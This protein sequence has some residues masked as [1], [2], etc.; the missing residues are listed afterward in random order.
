VADGPHGS[1]VIRVGDMCVDLEEWLME[2]VA[3]EWAYMTACN[4]GSVRLPGAENA[5]RSIELRERLVA[6]GWQ[7][8]YGVSVGRDGGWREPSF[9][10]LGMSE[11]TAADVAR[12]FGQNAFVAGRMGEPARLVWVTD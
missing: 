6:D 9:L 10:V 1:F 8:V 2:E 7:P 3:R 5:R 4:P 12:Q 11:S